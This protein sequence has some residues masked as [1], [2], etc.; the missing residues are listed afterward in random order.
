MICILDDEAEITKVIAYR[1]KQENL[2]AA[3][4]T[5]PEE[6]LAEVKEMHPT[7]F[8]IDFHMPKM[9]GRE[10]FEALERMNLT[11]SLPIIILSGTVDLNTQ[12]FP[13]LPNIHLMTK[14]CEYRELLQILKQ[15]A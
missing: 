10:V 9:N 1:L 13:N 2:D 3:T 15:A 12:K 6:F 7:G 5:S 14:P 8:I 11:Q 4:F